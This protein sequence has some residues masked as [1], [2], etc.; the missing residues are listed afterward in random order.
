MARQMTLLIELS[1]S[2]YFK[3]ESTN[4]DCSLLGISENTVFSNAIDI[5]S[6]GRHWKDI[7]KRIFISHILSKN[8][9]KGYSTILFLS[10]IC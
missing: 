1:L 2:D 6:F 10:G 8:R 3:T 9:E 7:Y 5:V 4:I